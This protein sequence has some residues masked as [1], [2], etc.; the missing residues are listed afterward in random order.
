M[1]ERYGRAER[2]A[3]VTPALLR[4]LGAPVPFDEVPDRMIVLRYPS[5]AG[6]QAYAWANRTLHG[7]LVYGPAVVDGL[8]VVAVLDFSEAAAEVERPAPWRSE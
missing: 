1:V 7:L 5:L 3:E 2:V 4:L 8:G 6:A